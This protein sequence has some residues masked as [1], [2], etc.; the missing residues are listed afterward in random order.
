MDENKNKA[1]HHHS[2]GIYQ[3]R[4]PENTVLYQ[5]LQEDLETW[6]KQT[7]ENGGFVSSHVEKD[8]RADLK[9]GLLCYG[10][11]QARYTC[12]NEFWSLKKNLLSTKY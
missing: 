6:I 5:I 9:C 1:F 3:P 2:P 4:H 7:Q 12:G 8:F 11:S 10:F